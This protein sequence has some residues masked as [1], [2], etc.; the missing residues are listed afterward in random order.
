MS[1]EPKIFPLNENPLGFALFTQAPEAMCVIDLETTIQA[2]N[3]SFQKL[4][5]ELNQQQSLVDLL[6]E[7]FTNIFP[8]LKNSTTEKPISFEITMQTQSQGNRLIAFT[9]RRLQQIETPENK[10]YIIASLSDITDSN[11]AQI[12]LIHDFAFYSEL[13]ELGREINGQINLNQIISK[14]LDCCV[15]HGQLNHAAIVYNHFETEEFTEGITTIHNSLS[16]KEVVKI[17]CRENSP[18]YALKSHLT[19]QSINKTP[20]YFLNVDDWDDEKDQ[21]YLRA[22]QLLEIIA[23]PIRVGAEVTGFLLGAKSNSTPY[24]IDIQSRIQHLA[25]LL[26]AA[27]RNAMLFHQ[28]RVKNL[29]L[30]NSIKNLQRAED[31]RDQFYRF[32]IHDLNKPL[33]SII[34]TAGRLLSRYDHNEQVIQRLERINRSALRLR[35]YI[36]DM[37]DFERLRRGEIELKFEEA[38]IKAEI[39]EAATMILERYPD[40]LI[41][42]NNEHPPAWGSLQPCC[43]TM[44]LK[45]FQ[46]IVFNLMDNA[47]KYG[48]KEVQLQYAVNP[49]TKGQELSLS[50]WN[51]GAV[52]PVQERTKIFDEFYRRDRLQETEGS[53]IGLAS[54]RCLVRALSGSILVDS[55]A[56][57][58]NQFVVRFPEAQKTIQNPPM[59]E[60]TKQ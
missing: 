29:E 46:R 49:S 21:L 16:N 20:C 41:T 25:N 11:N 31:H 37:L 32:L 57:G 30:G 34:G 27:L 38:D 48:E 45:Q 5:G 28:L 58:G 24:S 44:D 59:E 22:N 43:F 47:C 33:A 54:V 10:P 51:N 9:V 23:V 13:E 26:S 53:G 8:Y 12:A 6:A 4:F 35:D 40:H 17:L 56:V 1:Q 7:E 3:T 60:P 15:L 50:I 14:T 2:C 55:P 52:I 39:I 42:I 36:E 19:S 18:V